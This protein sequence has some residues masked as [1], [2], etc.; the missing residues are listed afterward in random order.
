MV[1]STNFPTVVANGRGTP[2]VTSAACEQ[3]VF[4]RCVNGTGNRVRVGR[5]L[6]SPLCVLCAVVGVD[7]QEA[8][9]AL[10]LDG[11]VF[12]GVQIKVKRPSNFQRA[13]E[14]GTNSPRTLSASLS[15]LVGFAGFP[16]NR[17]VAHLRS[18]TIVLL[19]DGTLYVDS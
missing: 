12:N 8:T 1:V 15:V 14:A 7:L 3:G 16:P 10:A 11:I 18:L 6:L 13:L 5:V 19:V 4:R 9:Q 2:R 17:G